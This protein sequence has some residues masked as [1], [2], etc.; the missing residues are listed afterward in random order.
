MHAAVVTTCAFPREMSDADFGL[1]RLVFDVRVRA[2]ENRDAFDHL[3]NGF[4]D[5]LD[6][7]NLIHA[8]P[9]ESLETV[10]VKQRAV[11]VARYLNP[12]NVEF[13]DGVGKA[14][15]GVIFWDGSVKKVASLNNVSDTEFFAPFQHAFD[16]QQLKPDAITGQ[17]VLDSLKMNVAYHA[18]AGHQSLSTRNHDHAP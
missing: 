15:L 14:Q 16:C 3:D 6:R 9:V 1:G 13:S 2:N 17:D 5:H 18:N 4:Q 10:L 12:L 11:M 7:H 8:D